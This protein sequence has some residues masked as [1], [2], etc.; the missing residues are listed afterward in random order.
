MVVL[1]VQNILLLLVSGLLVN[2]VFKFI[3][4]PAFLSPLAKIPAGHWSAH[5]SPLWILYIRWTNQENA[6]I[7]RLHQEKGKILRLGPSEL[8][9]NDYAEGLKKIYM[10]GFPKN[11]FYAHR[12][13]NYETRNMFT[14]I[15]GKEHSERKRMLS[16]VYSKSIVLSS[17]TTRATTASIMYKR[18]LPLLQESSDKGSPIEM[19]ELSYGY[20]MDAFMAY[21]FGLSRGSNFI[22]D[23]QRRKWYLDLFFRR[24]PYLFFITE[25]PR[26]ISRLSRVGLRIVPKWVDAATDELETWNLDICDSAEQLLSQ[27]DAIPAEDYPVI[28]AQERLALRKA[29]QGITRLYTPR[30]DQT[31][32]FRYEIAS[33]MYDHNA[34]AHETS[35]DT[36]T[37]VHYEMAR[38]PALQRRLREELLTLD[39]PI[40]YPAKDQ[41]NVQLPDFKA[42]DGLPLL[43]AILQETLRLWVAVPGGQPRLTPSPPCSI[44]GYENIP[45]NTK[46]Q[47]YAYALHRNPEVYPEPEKWK[48][49]RWLHATPDKLSEMRRWF[50]AFGSGGRMCIGNNI[51]IHSMKMAI[52][53]T[54]TNFTSHI[55]EHGDMTL[56]D[57]FTAGP[58]GNRL[59][60]KFEHV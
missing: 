50:W 13:T 34:A 20:A 25:T 26:L 11:N 3:V 46:V 9:V 49:E 21:Q 53:A 55:V 33:D 54:Y 48:P 35:G 37:Y 2:L 29:Y 40:L 52:A 38:D 39:P 30:A 51:A 14:M 22:Q 47:C 42:V 60:L 10:G 45:P 56:V 4:Q 18:L 58:K 24:R 7:L 17:P 57:G 31:Y 5:F 41:E 28:Y 32:P 16:N 27:N 12:F 1:G 6:T 44:A 15:D 36:L 43:D 8:S 19:L 23:V 59:N